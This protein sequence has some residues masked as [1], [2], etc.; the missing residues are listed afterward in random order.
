MNEITEQEAKEKWCP[1]VRFL[2]GPDTASWQGNG[3]NNRGDYYEPKTCL[4]LA[5]GCMAWRWVDGEYLHL[6]Y[7]G[8]AGK[9]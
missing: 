7:C 5:S 3:Y 4:C 8:K 1:E 9:P 2:I 6:G